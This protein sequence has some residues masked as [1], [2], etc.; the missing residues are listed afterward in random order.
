MKTK[1]PAFVAETLSWCNTQRIQQGKSPLKRLPKGRLRDGE[2][3]PC[4]T[5]TGL[6][7]TRTKFYKAVNSVDAIGGLPE[8]V[9][10]FV[11]AFDEGLL[12]QYESARLAP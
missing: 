5:A 2:S 10:A 4:G 1:E 8:S 3:C 7:V 9:K 12:P 6:F 11:D